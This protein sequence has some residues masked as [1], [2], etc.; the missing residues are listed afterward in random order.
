MK[1]TLACI[2]FYVA[3]LKTAGKNQTTVQ[4]N[5]RKR[6]RFKQSHVTYDSALRNGVLRWSTLPQHFANGTLGITGNTTPALVYSRKWFLLKG[7]FT[8]GDSRT[9]ASS[10]QR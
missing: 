8:G 7:V 10:V 9:Q 1:S 3:E 2:T 4:H 5:T 6:C